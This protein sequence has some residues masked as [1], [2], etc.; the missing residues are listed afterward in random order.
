MSDASHTA[1]PWVPRLQLVAASVFFSTAGA[2]IKACTLGAWPIA[3]VRAG[4]AALALLAFL[5]GARRRWSWRTLLVSLA[6]AAT[7]ILFVQAN[8]LTTAANAIFIGAT[9]PLFLVLL[10]PWLLKEPVRRRD[11]VFMM[12]LALGLSLFFVSQDP[13]ARTAP[14]PVL[15]NAL[16][17]ATSLCFA[18]VLI[19]LRWLERAE[20]D[21]AL[22]AVVAGNVLTFVVSLPFSWPYAGARPADWIILAFLGVFQ[23]G[24]AYALLLRGLRHLTAL[25]TA[26]LLNLEPILNPVWAWL[27]HGERPGAW[28]LA[29]G[30]LILGAVLARA[31]RD[32]RPAAR[33][34]AA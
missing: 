30:A 14:N 2:A 28:A 23:I 3:G 16:A 22:P 31:W 19:G 24:L 32:S 5:P 26:L 8:K 21:A 9:S 11:V 12:A 29:G 15:G 33:A 27:V 1:S 18:L 6:Y 10:G 25:E 20:H 7:I 13:P 4:V 34:S 17:A